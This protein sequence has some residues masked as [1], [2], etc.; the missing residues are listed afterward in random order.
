MLVNR[1]TSGDAG[2]SMFGVINI[3]AMQVECCCTVDCSQPGLVFHP[4]HLGN[5]MKDLQLVK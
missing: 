2:E 1:G 3:Q 4:V 5:L